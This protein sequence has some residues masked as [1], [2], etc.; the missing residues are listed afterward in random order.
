M[1]EEQAPPFFTAGVKTAVTSSSTS[2]KSKINHQS[3]PSVKCCIMGM[4]L[5]M[6]LIPLRYFIYV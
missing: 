5:L 4:L 3:H 2:A 6:Y 1:A